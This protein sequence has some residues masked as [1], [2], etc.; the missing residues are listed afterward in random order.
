MKLS[1][2]N[3]IC[4]SSDREWSITSNIFNFLWN[5][6]TKEGYLNSLLEPDNNNYGVFH[7]GKKSANLKGTNLTLLHMAIHPFIIRVM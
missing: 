3:T 4:Y 1:H 2:P 7:I 5:Y 6:N